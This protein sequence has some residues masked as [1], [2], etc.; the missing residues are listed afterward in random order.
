[1][2]TKQLAKLCLVKNC[3]LYKGRVYELL[4]KNSK[5][6]KLNAKAGQKHKYRVM[7]SDD[8]YDYV[9]TKT[10]KQLNKFLR[11]V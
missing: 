1:M 11:S 3:F 6:K 2:I 8:D 4:Y 9:D 5:E 10:T 7:I